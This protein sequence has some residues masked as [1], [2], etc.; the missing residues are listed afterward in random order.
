M[1]NVKVS[2]L[3]AVYN[4]ERTLKRCLESLLDQTLNNI[5]VI[6]VDDCSTDDSLNIL[7]SYSSRDSR[8][9]VFRLLEN[10]GQAVARNMG[11]DKSC[12][13]FICFLDSDDWLAVDALEKAVMTFEK[14]PFTDCVLFK[15]YFVENGKEREYPMSFF[16]VM[17]G[18]DAF[19][20]SLTW[21]VHGWYMVRA[22]LHKRF[23]YDDSCKSYSDDNTT[24][25]HYYYSREVRCC[26][27]TYYYYFNETSVT[28]KPSVR[29]FDY[30]KA[31]ESMKSQLIALKVSDD[32]IRVYETERWKILVDTYMFYFLNR[33]KLAQKDSFF[34]LSELKRVWSSIEIDKVDSSLK[35]KFGYI[36]LR[37]SWSLFR[38]QEETYFL[39]KKLLGII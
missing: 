4:A 12:G 25:I 32:V 2:V 19:I 15:V 27:G 17:S 34:G 14:H 39:L 37:F 7:N 38:L 10:K 30:I 24:R 35:K 1:N 16:S 9:K 29:R 13:D 20:G 31:N 18:Y 23:P 26:Q 8:I 28:K 6:C 21:K 36:P 22:S 11:L 33:K 5:E 3:V